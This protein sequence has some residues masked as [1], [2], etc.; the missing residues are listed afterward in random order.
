MSRQEKLLQ[1]GA[2]GSPHQW[3]QKEPA[4]GGGAAAPAD[5]FGRPPPPYPGTARPPETVAL[6]CPASFTAEL[7]RSS[8]EGPAP[9]QS[10]PREPGVQG[11]A[12]RWVLKRRRPGFGRT[13][14]SSPPTVTGRFA[15]PPGGLQGSFLKMSHPA[16]AGAALLVEHGV[17]VQMKR[18]GEF[19]GIR[20][21]VAP[22][23]HVMPG[24][25]WERGT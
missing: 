5:P 2:V 21:L 4:G 8:T 17:P 1:D 6:G 12:Q 10:L 3:V 19:A 13:V 7:A 14:Q 20:P 22:A 16:G 18:P 24:Q 9:R 23:G 15:A 25:Q 11:Q